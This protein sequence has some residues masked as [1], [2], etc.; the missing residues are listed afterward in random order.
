MVDPNAKTQTTTNAI[1]YIYVKSYTS[2]D[3]VIGVFIEEVSLLG[4]TLF[5][6]LG[7]ELLA[8]NLLGTEGSHLGGGGTRTPVSLV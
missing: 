5:H 6:A 2:N 4:G 3:K 8:L 7:G 1:K